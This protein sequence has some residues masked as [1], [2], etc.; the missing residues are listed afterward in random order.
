MA[1]SEQEE[2]ELL[3]LEELEAQESGQAPQAAQEG[4]KSSILDTFPGKVASA[5]VGAVLP[6]NQAFEPIRPTSS[7]PFMGALQAVGQTFRDPTRLQATMSAPGMM[8]GEGMAEGLGKAGV[9][10]YVGA[11]AGFATQAA[12]DPSTYIG[13]PKVLQAGGGKLASFA[14]RQVADAG[15][16]LSGVPARSIAK[17]FKNPKEVLTAMSTKEAGAKFQA[18]KKLAGVTKEEEFLIEKAGDRALGGARTVGDQL[19]PKFN[20]NNLEVM[21]TPAFSKVAE[22]PVRAVFIGNQEIPGQ[23]PVALFNILGKH[24]RAGSS[25]TLE[26]LQKEGITEIG[27]SARVPQ[28]V[29]PAGAEMTMGELVALNRAAGKLSTEAKGMGKALWAPIHGG[30]KR[31]IAERAKDVADGLDAVSISKTKKAFV[32]FIPRNQNG[33]PSWARLMGAGAASSVFGPA[34]LISIPAVTGVLTL[35]AKAAY[36]AGRPIAKAASYLANP[37]LLALRRK[38]LPA[39]E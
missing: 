33:R 24:P 20:L 32:D 12:L 6:S 30:A 28:G 18:A 14:G 29:I 37:A 1:L 7:N 16:A 23:A 34:G 4:P 26:A 38:Y 27:R 19:R 8:A 21:E 17:L 3:E 22:G 25:V 36:S 13:T 11:A 9:N 5:A 39:E 31:M 10:P 2:L 35:G 15:E